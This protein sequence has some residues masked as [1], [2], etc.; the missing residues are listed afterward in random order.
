MRRL[1]IIATVLAAVGLA[2]ACGGGDG[3]PS[4][5]DD[6]DAGATLTLSDAGITPIPGNSELLI[7]PNRFALA[8][9]DEENSPILEEPGL[10]VLLRFFFDD[11]LQFDQVADFTWAIQDA[12]GF[13]VVNVDFDQAGQWE[14]EPILTRDGEE[15]TVRRF[16]F[17]VREESQIPN[18]GDSPPPSM[19]LTLADVP[20]ISRISTDEEPEPALYQMTVAQALTAGR[21]A[22]V[23]FATPAFCQTRF[24]GPVVDNVKV[25]WEEFGD[26]VNF[27]HIEPFELDEEG[28]LVLDENSLPV[29]VTSTVEWQLLT[30]PWIFIVD[31]DGL[32]AARFENV[33]GPSELRA[34]I[35]E[36][37]G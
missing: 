4:P 27:I 25:V 33:I 2:A 35:E 14:V 12:N 5:A 21:P 13:F 6:A 17:P 34:A 29:P 9:I 24:C 15:T 19:N 11:E 28:L 3:T 7:G 26:R 10:N 22:V 36:T 23:V 16:S 18:I 32:I 20:D 31:A 8:L 37:L 30:E 1:L